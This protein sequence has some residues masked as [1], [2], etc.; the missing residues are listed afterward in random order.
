MRL[1]Q[2]MLALV[3]IA[4]V[5]HE[6]SVRIVSEHSARLS[7][8]NAEQ[9]SLARN[10]DNDELAIHAAWQFHLFHTRRGNAAELPVYSDLAGFIRG[11][12]RVSI[13]EWWGEM[14]KAGHLRR[15]VTVPR[16]SIWPK[17]KTMRL[18]SQ[19]AAYHGVKL[20][21]DVSSKFE[22]DVQGLTVHVPDSVVNDAISAQFFNVTALSN[23]HG[24]FCVFWSRSFWS[25]SL[26]CRVVPATG[27]LLW[28]AS[29]GGG[30]FSQFPVGYNCRDLRT[31]NS[32]C[33][34]VFGATSS[35]TFI[36]GVGIKD[37]KMFFEFSAL[38]VPD[39]SKGEMPPDPIKD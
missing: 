12:L 9:I 39:L 37:G 34:Y 29:L 32:G 26:V 3:L 6:P 15:D 21:S 25:H 27:E 10:D 19:F 13:P 23:N 18:D 24:T 8:M 16:E 4:T 33:L 31:T 35:N 17:V 1:F 14:L 38:N 5:T 36:E 28:T 22:L 30:K 7:Q 11:R 2:A 20:L